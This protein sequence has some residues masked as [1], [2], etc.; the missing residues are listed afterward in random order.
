MSAFLLIALLGAAAAGAACLLRCRFEQALPLTLYGVIL[1]AYVLALC[2]GLALTPWLVWGFAAVGGVYA[3]WSIFKKRICAA[4]DLLFGGAVFLA[5]ALLLWWLCRGCDLVDWDDFSHWGKSV[6]IMFHS[7]ELYTAPASS[8]E[9]KSYP[10]ATALLGYAL[11]RAVSGSFREDL[12]LFA[13]GL[14][15]VSVAC[16][17]VCLF[18]RGPAAGKKSARLGSFVLSGLGGG[19]LALLLLLPITLYARHYYMLGV[20]GLLGLLCALTL[21]AGLLADDS[22]AGRLAAVLGCGVL[23][24]VKSTGTGLAAMIAAVLAVT[25]LLR[26]DKGAAR[27]AAARVKL[28]AWAAAPAL[29]IG[30][31]KLS[32]KLHTTLAGVTERWV[33]RDPLLPALWQLV[34]GQGPDWR[35]EVIDSFWFNLLEDHNY[36]GFIRLSYA[37]WYLVFALLFGAALLLAPRASRRRIL[38]WGGTALGIAVVFTLSL[39]FSYLFMFHQ[40]EA[41]RLASL[42]R[43]LNTCLQMLMYT[44]VATLCIAAALRVKAA[45]EGG[46]A[47]LRSFAAPL[48]AV[49][50]ACCVLCPVADVTS[51]A[52]AVLEAPLYSAR[53]AQDRYFGRRIAQRISLLEDESPRVQLITANDAGFLLGRMDYEVL[54]LVMPLQSS[55]LMNEPYPDELWARK[56]TWQEWAEVLAAEFDYVYVHDFEPQ[57]A[58]EFY[59]IFG[60]RDQ[61]IADSMYRVVRQPD[62]SVLLQRMP[63][64]TAEQPPVD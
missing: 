56:C 63:E 19:A 16:W 3:L 23:T 62:G 34:S 64:I 37:N 26:R 25:W 31:A 53:T 36:L 10:P 38:V 8:D 32:W 45:A 57:F 9:F 59:P 20:D 50:A 46:S 24:L 13:N 22:L 15:S 42:S 5:A 29:A 47:S 18:C 41:V 1:A 39:L 4:D 55:I 40:R 21:A 28:L 6:K 14:L 17:P 44:G 52:T 58:E 49:L 30:A 43:Y 33:A 48:A 2:G 60:T 12:L 27:T 35:L 11:M 61:L 7:G 54:P 51:A